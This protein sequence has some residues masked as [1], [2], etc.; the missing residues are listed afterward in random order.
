[1][2]SLATAKDGVRPARFRQLRE[3]IVPSGILVFVVPLLLAVAAIPLFVTRFPPLADYPGHLAITYILENYNR[4]PPFQAAYILDHG[5]YPN[6]AMDILVPSLATIFG[7]E[8]SGLIFTFLIFVVTVC[9]ALL[10]NKALYGRVSI[11]A[12]F[13][14]C[15]LYNGIFA[16]GFMNYLFGLGMAMLAFGMYL[17][18]QE[19]SPISRIIV[20]SLLSMVVF[21][22]HLYAFAIYGILVISY[23]IFKFVEMQSDRSVRKLL[24]NLSIA[25]AQA[26]LPV[27]IFLYFSPMSSAHVVSQIQFG[28]FKRKL[29]ALSFMF[30][31][32]NQG[33]DLICYVAIA[34]FIGFM[35]GR[36]RIMIARPMVA[37]LVFLCGVFVI[38]PAVVF[39]SSSADRR[40]I[41]AIAL[42]AVSSLNLS[43]RSW[44]ELLAAAVT[45]GS[46]YLLQVG[47]AQHSWAAYEPRLRNYL[48]A[49]QKVKE[50]SNVAVAVDPNASWFP[51]N[52]RGV[53][54]LLVLQRNA[55]PSQQFLWRGQNPVALSE[56]FERMAEAA[57]WNEIYE[58]LLTIY[59]ARN[60]KELDDLVKGSLADFQY[61][62]VIHE[63][64]TTPSLADLGLDRIAYASDFD[65]YRLR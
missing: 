17:L 2:A 62:L 44:R 64:P 53:P 25:G 4:V 15:I 22:C 18:F 65:L 34:V 6:L 1:M 39:S 27:A 20:S 16:W 41:V 45:I 3:G 36:G 35:L 52:V 43:V 63:S 56:K 54:S 46:V 58:R 9:G 26:I 42:V 5:L 59:E 60:R 13:V 55:F 49:F 37:A 31:N 48:S 38:M 14:F 8:T 23:E 7:I 61:L 40:L 51:I 12:L 29:E 19:H 11:G 30:G 10:V 21:I 50:G 47:I 33:I 57:P 32:Y 28:N 24:R